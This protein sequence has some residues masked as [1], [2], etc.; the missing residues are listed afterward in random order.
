MRASISR[1]FGHF[2]YEIRVSEG[3]IAKYRKT[4]EDPQTASKGRCVTITPRGTSIFDF[5][6]S[7][8]DSRK[9]DNHIRRLQL[10]IAICNR[11]RPA[12]GRN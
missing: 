8:A 4:D 11:S 1:S 10:Q 9:I 6:F 2:S 12:K 3:K 7:I 5:G